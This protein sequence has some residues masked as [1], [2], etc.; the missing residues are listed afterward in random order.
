M[1]TTTNILLVRPANFMFNSQTET[2]NAFQIKITENN[3]TTQKLANQEFDK[4]A[5]T[6]KSHGVNVFVFDDTEIPKKPDAVFPNNWVTFHSDGTVVLYPMHAPNRQFERRK[7]IIDELGKS[8]NISNIL[9]FSGYEKSEKYLE[10]TGSVIFDHK[11]KKAFACISPR[12]N[13][14]LFLEVCKTLNYQPIS[15][16]SHDENAKEIYHTN[17]MMCIGEKFAAVCLKSITAQEERNI[18]IDSLKNTGHQIIDITFEQMKCF[19]G[20]ML[21]LKTNNN[22]NILVLS[23]SAFES[24]TCLQ[25]NEIEKYCQF[26]PLKINT[27]ETIGGGSVR[28]MI[29]EI[30]LPVL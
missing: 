20:N 1:Q 30:F 15:F 26:V 3:E 17:V 28:C 9:D 5:E 23:Q 18:V 4:F 7:D 25:K 21:E 29:A 13:K 19:A 24:L 27:I 11:N 8:F 2:S 6:L 10:G 16:Y 12:T 14:E 22:R